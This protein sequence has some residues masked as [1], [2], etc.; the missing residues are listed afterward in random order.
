MKHLK[1]IIFVFIFVLLLQTIF[2]QKNTTINKTAIINKPIDYKQN[3]GI[4]SPESILA[5]SQ[6]NFD[7]SLTT[8][9][10]VV[11]GMGVLVTLIAILVT[12][13]IGLGFFQYSKW[14]KIRK[15]A[16]KNL[17][18]IQEI[19]NRAENE[20]NES[21]KKIKDIS[22]EKVS[23]EDIGQIKHRVEELEILGIEAPARFFI[24][25]VDYY[26]KGNY[27]LSLKAFEKAI[28][29]DPKDNT[30]WVNKGVILFKLNKPEEALKAFEKAI[31]LDPK[32]PNVWFNIS[33]YYSIKNKKEEALLN[34]KK[35]IEL[36]SKHKDDAKKD[37]DFKFL[38]KDEDF[39][40][41]VS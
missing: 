38:W 8:L 13:A 37:E 27:E 11:T 26:K 12:I 34:L 41:L 9:N 3:Q 32:D 20:V 22:I 33:C 30:L 2:A 14:S 23:K 36:D 40:K 28:E 29:L 16:E 4:A 10:I 17:R 15:Q 21:I 31:E 5:E 39:K 18:E 1:L 6:R 19:R 7:R 25:G 24:R 35:A